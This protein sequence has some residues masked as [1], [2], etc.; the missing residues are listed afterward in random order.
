MA[1][2]RFADLSSFDQINLGAGVFLLHGV[3]IW[4]ALRWM[5]EIRLLPV[6]W[7]RA[8]HAVVYAVPAAVAW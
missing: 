7:S 8:L 4:V 6:I 1:P 5:S 2:V 3:G